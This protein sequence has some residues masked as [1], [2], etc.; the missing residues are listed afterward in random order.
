M[1]DTQPSTINSGYTFILACDQE[2]YRSYLNAEAS[3]ENP[4]PF[5]IGLQIEGGIYHGCQLILAYP[6][7]YDFPPDLRIGGSGGN[8]G[9]HRFPSQMQKTTP[10]IRQ[11]QTIP[12]MYRLPG[13]C[14][15]RH[16][17]PRQML[18]KTGR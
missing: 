14:R 11:A 7:T 2:P 8:H 9:N 13:M 6:D 12:G 10:G 3:G 16:P 17:S 4:S 18:W 15:Q 5:L 1:M